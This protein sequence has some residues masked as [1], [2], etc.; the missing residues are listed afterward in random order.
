[1]TTTQTQTNNN[2]TDFLL[3]PIIPIATLGYYLCVNICTNQVVFV[4]LFLLFAITIYKVTHI[5]KIKF[6]NIYHIA[7]ISVDWFLL[8]IVN[9]FAN[10]SFAS[11]NPSILETVL[12]LVF[13]QLA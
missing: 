11:L 6:I 1:M 13:T 12:K 4:V 3:S 2:I 10:N 5:V 7:I 9:L 8:D